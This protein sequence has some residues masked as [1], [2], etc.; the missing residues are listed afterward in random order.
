MVQ[1]FVRTKPVYR[2][3]L[4]PR[5]KEPTKQQAALITRRNQPRA[6]GPGDGDAKVDTEGDGKSEGQDMEGGRTLPMQLPMYTSSLCKHTH[7]SPGYLQGSAALHVS[8][9]MCHT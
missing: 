7:V 1:S 6:G 2:L 9:M 5:A 3:Q 8:H 4:Q